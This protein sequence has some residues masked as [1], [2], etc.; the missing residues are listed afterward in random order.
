[1][2]T[3]A[4][5]A[6]L[7]YDF[8]PQHT[9]AHFKVRH[10]MISNVKGEFT[11]V[12]GSVDFD[13]SN[14][15]ASSIQASIDVNSISTREPQRDE[16]LKSADFF[17]AANHPTITFRSKEITPAGKDSYE[18]VGDLTIRGVTRETALLVE[19]VTP[20][21]K[22]PWGYLRRGATA[23]TKVNRK[24]FGLAW[25]QALETGGFVVGDDVQINIDIELVRKAQ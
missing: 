3:P 23:S 15:A 9:A 25:N 8:D 19:D 1:M 21:V 2:S 7:H 16:H 14:P 5:A 6:V 20:E 22:D 17:D 4:T 12:A 13:P 18:V 11:R 24:D 10:L